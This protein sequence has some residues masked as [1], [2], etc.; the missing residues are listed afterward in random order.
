MICEALFHDLVSLHNETSQA[1]HV[2]ANMINSDAHK[3]HYWKYCVEATCYENRRAL[4]LI[5]GKIEGEQSQS[6]N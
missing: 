5:L 6:S 3:S 2:L 1:Y 4:T